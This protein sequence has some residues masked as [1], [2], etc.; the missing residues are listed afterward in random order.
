MA[1]RITPPR[2]GSVPTAHCKLASVRR[3]GRTRV[4]KIRGREYVRAHGPLP[5]GIKVV[6]YAKGHYWAM[7]ANGTYL[8]LKP[9]KKR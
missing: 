2:R 8:R 9:R 7:R 4:V 6:C 1:K 5:L 3:H